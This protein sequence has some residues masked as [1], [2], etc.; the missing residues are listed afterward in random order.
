MEDADSRLDNVHL[1]AEERPLDNSNP[2]KRRRTS[3][4]TIAQTQ[5]L[6]AADE[7]DEIGLYIFDS[8]VLSVAIQPTSTTHD[9]RKGT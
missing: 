8:S 5:P 7:D 1:T 4:M 6:Q 9:D 3:S 2:P